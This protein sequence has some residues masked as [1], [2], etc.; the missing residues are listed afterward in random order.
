VAAAL[1]TSLSR[2]A[3]LVLD[4][5]REALD[6]ANL[7]GLLRRLRAGTLNRQ[8]AIRRYLDEAYERTRKRRERAGQDAR[9]PQG[10]RKRAYAAIVAQ[11]DRS[12]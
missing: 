11:I 7:A 4:Y 1:P 9:P 6:P 12:R 8:A 5:E 3:D 2:A 10:W